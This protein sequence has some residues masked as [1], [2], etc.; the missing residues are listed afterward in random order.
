MNAPAPR[1]TP[2]DPAFEAR[3]RASF[4]TQRYLALLGT[5]LETV[6][7]GYV[8]M[9]LSGRPD[10][11]QQHGYFHGGAI[12]SLFDSASAY[13]AFT[14]IPSHETILTVEYKLNLLAPGKGDRL[15]VRAQVIKPG[16]TLTVV[17]ADAFGASAEGESLCATTI[18]TLMAVP[19]RPLTPSD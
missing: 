6:R 7:P 10:L 8:E 5:T 18:Q 15:I 3:I 2:K 9:H 19:E 11:L 1:F 13:A 4:L 16:R 14:L 17:Q 12:A